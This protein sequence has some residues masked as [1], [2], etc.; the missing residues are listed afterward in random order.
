METNFTISTASK[1]SKK[2]P[3][4]TSFL[5]F[6]VE[7]VV[8]RLQLLQY[9]LDDGELIP[10]LLFLLVDQVLELLGGQLIAEGG[11]V[12]VLELERG[13]VEIP[14]RVIGQLIT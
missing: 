11:E 4:L 8:V 6:A 13:D 5:H 9:V 14:G 3:G 7:G 2:G 10:D 12:V 1:R